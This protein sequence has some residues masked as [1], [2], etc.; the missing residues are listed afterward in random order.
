[1]SACSGLLGVLH[2]TLRAITEHTRD[3]DVLFDNLRN[4]AHVEPV[5]N[6]PHAD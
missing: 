1:M 3:V 2:F 4:L 5:W 6:K